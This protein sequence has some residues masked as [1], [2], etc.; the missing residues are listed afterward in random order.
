MAA[1]GGNRRRRSERY[2]QTPQRVENAAQAMNGARRGYVPPAD[3]RNDGYYGGYDPYSQNA[4][5]PY[6]YQ[7]VQQDQFTGANYY[8]GVQY[9][10]GAG[11]QMT[12]AQTS[13]QNRYE[14]SGQTRQETPAREQYHTGSYNSVGGHRGYVVDKQPSGNVE[15]DNG[16]RKKSGSGRA[17]LII[18]I[19]VLLAGIGAGGYYYLK[20]YQRTQEINNKVE[21]YNN[22][23]CPGVY[24]DGIN[25]AGMTP[26][27]AL[28]SV[29]SQIQQR[30]DAWSVQLVYEGRIMGTINAEMLGMS[31]SI[32]DVLNQ[33]WLQGHDGDNEQ[34]Y[35]AMLELEQN[36]Y[37]GYTAVP[38]GDNA[39][40]DSL[41]AQL[42][43]QID[44]PAEDAALLS[45][46]P[47]LSYPFTFKDEVYGKR[48]N[49]E[50]V[51]EE[52]YR[53]V[54]EM[55]TGTVE[56]VPD[57]VYPNVTKND[58]QLH[59]MLRSSVY[60]P[61][62]SSSTE[63]RNN[64]IRRA[65][66]FINGYVL[67]S[68]ASFSFNNVV[69]ER[70]TNNGFFTA[71][72]YA[73]GEH[74]EGV[75]GGVCQASTTVYQAAVEAGLQ[76]TK[77]EPHS[78][79]VSY[80]DYGKDATVYW[81]G[82]RKIDLVFKNNTEGPIYIVAAVQEDP[83]NKRRLI[84]KVS[85][86]GEYMGDVRYELQAEVVQELEAP[87]EPVYVKDKEGTYVTYTDQQKSVSKAQPGYVVQ[88]YRLEYTGNELT[89]RKELYT[90]TYEPKP[91]RIYVGT[92][93]RGE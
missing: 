57:T 90:D 45:F 46:D 10:Y 72:E 66:E 3:S 28:N 8:D 60:T 64:N 88:S 31:V 71:I 37:H 65:F 12:G 36:P 83:S 19:I 42:K 7:P 20:E 30:N 62:A 50:P 74:V 63:N 58:L 73:Y 49:T 34:R 80:T 82:K 89:A 40:I 76:I 81:V 61:I 29:Q 4:G 52:L 24:V 39:A 1:E 26:E 59:Y 69:G 84:A 2:E 79:A 6:P 67:A 77:R 70:T 56:L 44:T 9:G 75:G 18:T 13:V 53:M 5:Q 17:V 14:Y 15:S 51:I 68:G 11:G 54:S 41:L 35:A 22:L 91:E 86:Y 93:K 27:Q 38:S 33:A 16:K 85:M 21:P 43:S 55:K 25:L 48:L 78:D 32:G 23:F 87:T 47:D 92:K